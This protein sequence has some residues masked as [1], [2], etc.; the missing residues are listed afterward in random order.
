MDSVS[1]TLMILGLLLIGASLLWH[2]TGG[3]IPIGKLP[4]D[5]KIETENTK[6]YFPITTG[7]I[8]SLLFSLLA[9]LFRK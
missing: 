8:L 4:G 5:I 1:K 9:Y 6:I 7:L 3:N 2:L